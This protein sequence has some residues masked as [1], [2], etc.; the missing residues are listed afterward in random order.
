MLGKSRRIKRFKSKTKS[1]KLT[2]IFKLEDKLLD[3]V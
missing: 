3:S 1:Y 2:E